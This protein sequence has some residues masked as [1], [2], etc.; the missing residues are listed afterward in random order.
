MVIKRTFPL[1]PDERNTPASPNETGNSI[2]REGPLPAVIYES[3]DFVESKTL[4]VSV[5][6]FV[7]LTYVDPTG[8]VPCE[9][10]PSACSPSAAIEIAASPVAV[11]SRD[12]EPL[13]SVTK[14][15]SPVATVTCRI[16]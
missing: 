2:P 11:V 7:Q 16:R 12:P 3:G 10:L 1:S 14:D 13:A 15:A 5:T 9:G 6:L 8:A 4:A